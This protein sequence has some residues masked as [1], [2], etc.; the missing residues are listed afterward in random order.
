MGW[1]DKKLWVVGGDGAFLDI[2]F[3]SLSRMLMSGMDIK[4]LVLDTQGYSNTGGQ[5]SMASYMSQNAD[6]AS[7]VKERLDLKGNPSVKDDW[8]TI[9]KTKE[10]IDFVT[11]AAT[12]GR[13]SKHFDKD[14]NPSPELLLA[15]QERLENWHVLQELAGII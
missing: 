6:F 11:F 9:R 4:V 5:A 8:Y 3:Q 2:G 1:Q 13:F 15:Q 12:E 14:G 10:T 7:I